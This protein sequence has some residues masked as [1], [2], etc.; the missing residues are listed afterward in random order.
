MVVGSKLPFLLSMRKIV[1]CRLFVI[2]KWQITHF[3]KFTLGS[4]H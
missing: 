4:E 3:Y 1:K 2:K